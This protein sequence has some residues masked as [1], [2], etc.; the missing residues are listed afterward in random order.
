ML[1]LPW[2]IPSQIN[3]RF[4]RNSQNVLISI[5]MH[6][7]DKDRTT[8]KYKMNKN[9]SATHP[10]TVKCDCPENSKS[11]RILWMISKFRPRRSLSLCWPYGIFRLA[12]SPQTKNRIIVKRCDSSRWR[13][14]KHVLLWLAFPALV[15]LYEGT[16]CAFMHT[17]HSVFL[18]WK[19]VLIHIF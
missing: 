16:T 14:A 4:L 8:K 13:F 17:I 6:V 10:E 11:E 3:T 15:P 18:K 7:L 2:Q 19:L 9:L 12:E 5:K 1:K